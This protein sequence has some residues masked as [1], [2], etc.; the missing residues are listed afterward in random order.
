MTDDT[1]VPGSTDYKQLTITLSSDREIWLTNLRQS[2]TYG[3]L[4]CGYPH[5]RMN[6][7]HIETDAQSAAKEFDNRYPPVMIP[8]RIRTNPNSNPRRIMGPCEAE[9]AS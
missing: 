2:Q 9:P 7:D 5:R 3:G 8:P 1:A 6:E 4:L